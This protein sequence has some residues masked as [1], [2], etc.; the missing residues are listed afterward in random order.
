MMTGFKLEQIDFA[1]KRNLLQDNIWVKQR[2]EKEKGR[3]SKQHE[4]DISDNKQPT[5]SSLPLNSYLTIYFHQDT[6]S[7]NAWPKFVDLH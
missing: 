4:C 3:G 2:W 1:G 5:G 6:E 7:E